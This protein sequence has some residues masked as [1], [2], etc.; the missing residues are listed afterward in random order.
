[1]K[2]QGAP[3]TQ[4]QADGLAGRLR[5]LVATLW[6]GSL[7][8][9]GYVAAPTLFASLSD[10]VLAGTI[11]GSLFRV[12]A[13]LSLAC[14]AILLLLIFRTPAAADTAMEPGL[15]TGAPTSRRR[16]LQLVAAM[17][18][19]TV[20]GYFGLQ[21]FMAAIRATAAAAGGMQ[22]DARLHFGLLHGAASGIYLIQSL[23][24]GWLIV[25]LR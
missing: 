17:A 1:L 22:A 16:L 21:P 10:R 6:V 18:L 13:W 2:T 9:I 5:L 24:G 3:V 23:L 12:E 7:W 4:G 11:A 14:A 15:K 8:A 20:F 19:C 25:R